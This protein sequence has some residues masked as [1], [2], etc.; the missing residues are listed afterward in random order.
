MLSGFVSAIDA[1]LPLVGCACCGELAFALGDG[2]A[3]RVPV[4]DAR[5]APLR[6]PDSLLARLET[7]G[8]V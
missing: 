5:M 7:R 6:A 4:D 2:G 1:T 3:R 8:D